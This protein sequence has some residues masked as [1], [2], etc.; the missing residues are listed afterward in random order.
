[1]V[2]KLK[3]IVETGQGDADRRDAT[4]WCVGITV[5]VKHE[6]IYWTQKGPDDAG[7][8]RIFRAST[9]IPKGHSASKRTDIEVLFDGL[10]EPIDLYLD[11]NSRMLY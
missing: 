10:P 8:G 6:Q 3:L 7:Q 2:L 11:L 4:K 5:D 1:M 9:G